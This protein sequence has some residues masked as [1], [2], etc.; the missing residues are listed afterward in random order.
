MTAYIVMYLLPSLAAV[1]AASRSG[2]RARMGLVWLLAFLAAVLLIGFRHEVGGD[3]WSYLDHLYAAHWETP[4]SILAG[5]DPGYELLNW[6]ADRFGLGI[7]AVNLVCGAIFVAGLFAF[8]RRQPNPWLALAVAVPYL[9]I[10]V[11]MGYS[12]QSVAAGLAMIGLV[13]LGDGKRLRFVVWLALA[14]TFHRSAIVL[15]PLAVLAGDR[16]RIWAALWIGAASLLL[17][18]L[19]LSETIDTLYAVY[20]EA[21]YAS[22]GAL[23]RVFMNAVP[24]LLFLAFRRRFP[25]TDGERRLWTWIAL[26]ALLFVP[27][28]AVSPSSTAVDRVALYLI[29]LQLFVFARLPQALG[30]T[31]GRVPVTLA[32]L[33]Y[34]GAVLFVWLT[35]AA[36]AFAWL[37]YRFY[38]LL[39]G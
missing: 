20:I 37:P 8:C 27:A 23:V 15:L 6:L 11:A 25:L 38:P 31:F 33:G 36:H 18:L 28:L 39:Q 19:L 35:Y 34:Y 24:A 29:P 1:G 12:R 32:V 7:Y 5:S 17:Y 10:V 13:A 21:Q 30:P 3:W 4:G 16:H 9:L 2:I 22:E 14:A 26:L